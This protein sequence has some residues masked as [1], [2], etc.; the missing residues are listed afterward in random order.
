MRRTLALLAATWL[1]VATA[2]AASAADTAEVA[3]AL[4]NDG[5]YV[6][7]GASIS[8]AQAG[9]LV[10]QLRDAGEGFSLVVLSEEP[11]AGATTFADNVQFELG[12]G[13]ILVVAPES[14]GLAGEGDVYNEL[15]LEA[16]LDAAFE[17]LGTDFEVAAAFV[18]QLTGAP[19]GVPEPVP[20]STVPPAG[21]PATP[22]SGGGSGF[23][24]F[25]L[26]AGGLGLLV[27][28]WMRRSRA[29]REDQVDD[30][31]LSQ[32]RY[33]IQEQLNDVANDILA[34]EDE[35]RVADNERASDFYEQA[36]ETYHA[37]SESLEDTT[38]AE[39][40]L[41]LSNRL[42]MAI[43]Q[44]DSAEAILDGKPLPAR[45]EPKRLEPEPVTA[46]PPTV[47]GPAYERRPQRSS[48]F[49]T[50]GLMDLLIMA[51]GA[52]LSSRR[53]SRFPGGGLGDLFGRRSSPSPPPRSPSTSTRPPSTP[54]PG[55]GRP[56]T[57]SSSRTQM[58]KS[59][60]GGTSGR[61]R[62]GRKRRRK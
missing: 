44:L 16:A 52:V 22:D 30:E 46:P 54:V 51:G 25:V 4:A 58:P 42:D 2:P 36:A 32:A 59:S 9:E 53:R 29:K 23:L 49:G 61:I 14:I 17:V 7:P 34:M 11:A 28:W 57:P 45:P 1:V 10:G 13:L 62:S 18:A 6:E 3:A 55:P 15:E 33:L 21:E 24:W 56:A 19:V 43:W 31:R 39:G 47:P 40:L 41:D 26:I 27:W 8:E 48:S 50:G 20:A 12:R 37:A 60:R 35:V 5:F 38:T